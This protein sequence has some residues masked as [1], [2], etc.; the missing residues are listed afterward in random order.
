MKIFLLQ[1][2]QFSLRSQCVIKRATSSQNEPTQRLLLLGICFCSSESLYLELQ[3]L[4]HICR[5]GI[6]GYFAVCF[7]FDEGPRERVTF[8]FLCCSVT[9]DIHSRTG[10]YRIHN[11]SEPHWMMRPLQQDL[12][13]TFRPLHHHFRSNLL[14]PFIRIHRVSK[15]GFRR[16]HTDRLLN[17]IAVSSKLASLAQSWLF[18]IL[19]LTTGLCLSIL[20]E[21]SC[22]YR[23]CPWPGGLL[24][25]NHAMPI[26]DPSLVSFTK[27]RFL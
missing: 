20:L 14:S 15:E 25:F 22:H 27:E 1:S 21:H 5:W 23:A 6:Y 8:Q 24:W 16:R 19:R 11:Y 17:Y 13:R 9:F 12:E 3:F 2:L 18:H 7:L 4:D 10:V 26:L